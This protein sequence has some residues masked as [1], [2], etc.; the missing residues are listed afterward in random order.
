VRDER[1][2]VLWAVKGIG[3]GGAERLLVSFAALADHDRFRYH[4]AHVVPWKTAL[5]PDLTRLGVGVHCLGRGHRGG[6]LWPWRL[7]R[8]LSAGRYDVV[9]F[10]SPLV[11]G[12]GRFVVATLPRA[13]R[14]A[15]VSTEHN[16]WDGYALPT[17]LLNA[18]RHHRDAARWAVSRRVL[19]SVWP[20]RREGMEVLVHG[21]VFDSLGTPA[22]GARVR[23]ELGLREDELVVCTVANFRTQKAYPDLLRAAR[24]VLEAEPGTRFLAV[25]QGPEGHRIRELHASL[26]LCD[27]FLLLGY[28]RDVG[29]VLA[30]SDVFTLASSVEGFPIA[31]MEAMA[32]GLPVVATGVGGLPDAVQ[33]GV[34]G[35]LVPAGRPDLLAQALLRVLGDDDLRKRMAEAAAARGRD[36]DMR[37][38]VSTVQDAYTAVAR[39]T[40]AGAVR[41]RSAP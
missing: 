25:G 31:V 6:V 2:R 21:L 19:D 17:R 5:V 39:P 35:L 20:S 28:R 38:V 16:T 36:F 29:A 24:I 14:P 33:D 41:D 12:V 22:D 26:G 7:R 11:A 9:H 34:H 8:L 10:H 18:W 32:A 1:V 27:R 30:A 3:A 40:T 37:P 23:A 4:A 13:R 15:V